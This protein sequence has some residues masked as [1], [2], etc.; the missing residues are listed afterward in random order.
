MNEVIE[1]N[2]GRQITALDNYRQAQ[3]ALGLWLA[4]FRSDNTRRAYRNEILSFASFT[5]HEDVAKAIAAFLGLDD[6]PAHA[7]SDAW[8]QDKL[9]RGLSPASINRSMAALNSFVNSAR[10]YGVTALRLEAKGEASKAYRDT[11]GPG[12][13]G[14][15]QLL[16]AARDQDHR[17]AA[18]DVAIVRL[19][20]GLGLR[21]GEIASLD[22][23]HADIAAG[24]LS[25][26]GKGRGEREPLTL[27][28]EIKDALA[29]WLTWRNAEGPDAPL[30]ICLQKVQGDGRISGAGI[31]HLIRDQLGRRAGINARPHGLRHTAVTAALD[32]F[33]GDY[34]KVRAFS[35]HSSLDIVRRYDDNRA[36]HGGQVAAALSAIVA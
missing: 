2:A 20:F 29:A 26:M 6:G 13:R 35:R 36:D 8:R 14:I 3:T 32:V 16:A 5:G 10:R 7:L 19:A 4:G 30:F 9:R 11:K 24:S 34:R 17:K 12:V 27:P 28:P 15:Q 22:V 18:R 33:G 21:R 25:I 31:Y 23:C 1:L